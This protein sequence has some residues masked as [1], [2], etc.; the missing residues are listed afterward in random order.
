MIVLAYFHEP[1]FSFSDN[2]DLRYRFVVRGNK[3]QA[4]IGEQVV[5]LQQQI[6]IM[7]YELLHMD[8]HTFSDTQLLLLTDNWTVQVG[9]KKVLYLIYLNLD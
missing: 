2:L 4:K 7:P 3:E 9:A 5:V 1:L 6:G 8:S